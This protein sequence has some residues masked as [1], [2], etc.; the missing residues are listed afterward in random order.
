MFDQW[1]LPLE[2]KRWQSLQHCGGSADDLPPLISQLRTTAENELL[3]FA[4]NL[5]R[6]IYFN[7]E[8]FTATFAAIPHL[9]L[10]AETRASL[11]PML[12]R[13]AGLIE[14]CDSNTVENCER[15]ILDA[16]TKSIELLTKW[17]FGTLLN[18]PQWQFDELPYLLQSNMS[19]RHP[20]RI[21]G[22]A[23]ASLPYETEFEFS[24]SC[25]NCDCELQL[26]SNGKELVFDNYPEVNATPIDVESIVRTYRV[27]SNEIVT[28][29]P[30]VWE[31]SESLPAMLGIIRSIGRNDLADRL[32]GFLP[33]FSCPECGQL[34][35]PSTWP[36]E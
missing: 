5:L 31:L 15:D 34:L 23:L 7:G 12:I 6:L 11:R 19:L 16:Y 2:S 27:L 8:V 18:L 4:D 21:M 29:E 36:I 26:L 24:G 32:A 35:D 22:I 30:L 20:R 13:T 9:T 33:P 3:I 28:R 25:Q 10:A 17:S 14:M 1:M